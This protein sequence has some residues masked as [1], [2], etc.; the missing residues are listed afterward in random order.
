MHSKVERCSE[1]VQ[2]VIG[3]PAFLD[4]EA[5][6]RVFARNKHGEDV[7]SQ[8]HLYARLMTLAVI[9]GFA[10]DVPAAID[11]QLINPLVA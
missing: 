6:P 4:A 11:T 2:Q 3:T 9:N 10:A 5:G 8:W 7:D 1:P